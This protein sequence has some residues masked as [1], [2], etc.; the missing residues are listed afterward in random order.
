MRTWTPSTL[1]EVLTL[2]DEGLAVLHPSHRAAFEAIRVKP[3][4]N[5]SLNADVPHA[6]AD[7]RRSGPPDS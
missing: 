4:P 5:P 1:D 2:L 7:A 3:G 6:W